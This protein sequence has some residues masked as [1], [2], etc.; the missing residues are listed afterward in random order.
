MIKITSNLHFETFHTGIKCSVNSLVKNRVT[1][2]DRWSKLDEIVRFLSN[3]ECDSKKQ[4][5]KQH[6][7]VMGPVKVGTKLYGSEMIVRGFEYFATSRA[8][9]SRL[10]SDYKLPSIKTLS[11]IT[12]KASKISEKHFF[13]SVFNNIEDSQ[14]LCVLLN[15]EVYVK[16]MLL[17]HGGTLFD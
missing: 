3:M 5:I 7:E 17:Y 12:S 6:V 4:V 8:L 9:Y 14:K 13:D 16:K 2:L 1:E 10:V 11:R 15:D